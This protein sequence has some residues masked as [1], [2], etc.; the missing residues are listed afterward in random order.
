LLAV[1]VFYSLF[2]DAQ[3]SL[4]VRSIGERLGWLTRFTRPITAGIADVAS[5]YTRRKDDGDRPE[6]K[7]E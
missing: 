6:R 3:E 4:I 2:D 1:P 5:L 7:N